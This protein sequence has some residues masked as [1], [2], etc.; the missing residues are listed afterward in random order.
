[1]TIGTYAELKTAIGEWA[2]RADTDF[3][4]RTGDFIALAEGRLNDELGAIEADATLRGTVDDRRMATDQSIAA[5]PIEEAIALF[6]AEDDRDEV[7]IQLQADG[8]FPYLTTSGRPTMAA[9]D[10]DGAYL[11]FDRP[12][13][14][15]YSFRLRY[16]GRIALSDTVT[17]NWLLQKRPDVYLA[18]A[19]MWGAGYQEDW[20]NGGI[21]GAL[22]ESAIPAIRR[23]LSLRKKGTLRVD[24]ALSSIG[25][26]PSFDYTS[27][28]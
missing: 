10:E 17:T 9:L 4:G 28:Q 25:R 22:L 5:A 8:S 19:M 18:A 23:T 13:D 7:P 15:D 11:D 12:L 21:W 14:T 3:T 16:R 6:L 26:R 27:G 2:L 1:M 24:P 20:P